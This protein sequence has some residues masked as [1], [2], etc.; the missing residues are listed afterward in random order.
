MFERMGGWLPCDC[1]LLMQ[2]MSGL[3][4]SYEK[5]STV[6]S[7]VVVVAASGATSLVSY[8]SVVRFVGHLQLK[9]L[10][11]R[12]VEAYVCMTRLLAQWAACDP[13]TLSEERVRDYFLHLVNARSYAPKTLRQARAALSAFFIEMLGVTDWRVFAHIKTRTLKHSRWCSRAMR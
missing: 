7:A 4:Q 6:S 8:P 12:T 10:A 11:P 13:A 5:T 9:G 1:G 2:R 3:W